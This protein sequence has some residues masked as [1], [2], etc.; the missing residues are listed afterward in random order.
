MTTYADLP[1]ADRIRG[2]AARSLARLP[3]A[4]KRAL[5]REVPHEIDSLRLDPDVRAML[6]AAELAGREKL[7][8]TPLELERKR[9]VHET[10]AI[11]GPPERLYDV[12]DLTV[13]GPAGPLAARLYSPPPAE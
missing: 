1:P 13:P 9:F 3:G 12:R 6:G 8:D 10:V 4:L 5:A 11:E 2:A 7:G